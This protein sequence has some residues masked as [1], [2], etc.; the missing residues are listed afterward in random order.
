MV[1]LDGSQSP[2]SH[3]ISNT[4]FIIPAVI[5]LLIVGIVVYKLINT[6][7]SKNKKK[8]EK[9]K[10][11]LISMVLGDSC[12]TIWKSDWKTFYYGKIFCT[13]LYI[14]TTTTTYT[15][16][17]YPEGINNTFVFCDVGF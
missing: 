17:F 9:K 8:E 2:H 6:L 12:N 15:E 10:N 13:V 11:L 1:D 7:Q 3:K 5:V 14:T 16:T 4:V